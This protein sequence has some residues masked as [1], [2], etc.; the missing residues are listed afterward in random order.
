[1]PFAFGCAFALKILLIFTAPQHLKALG[2][3]W[4]VKT[5][6]QLG[7]GFPG[8]EVLRVAKAFVASLSADEPCVAKLARFFP[9]AV[10]VRIPVRVTRGA[11]SENAVIEFGTQREVLFASGL[12][13]DFVDK[14]RLEN[15]DGSLNTEA[16]IVA[17]QLHN[18]N[19]AVAARFV[20]DVTN[21]IVKR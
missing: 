19:A 2:P 12:P 1:M 17:M 13:L 10:P 16:E 6:P 11:L 20:G 8:Q 4:V 14:V 15:S 18:G 5:Q 7:R 21:W 9:E 3:W